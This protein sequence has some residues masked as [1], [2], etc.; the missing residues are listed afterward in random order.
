MNGSKFCQNGLN[1]FGALLINPEL[2]EIVSYPGPDASIKIEGL[3]SGKIVARRYRNRRIGEL[4]K[5]LRLTEGRS[6]GI[7]TIRRAMAENGS[8]AVHFSTDEDRTYFLVQIPIHPLFTPQVM[9]VGILNGEMGRIEMQKALK[10]KDAKY[11]RKTYLLPA[12]EGGFIEMTIPD[13]PQSS[14]QRY[15]LTAKGKKLRNP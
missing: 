10:L 13:M 3:N 9:L 6:T 4:L 7:P 8:P 1:R 11:F 2:I 15:R 5:E 14:K 12:L